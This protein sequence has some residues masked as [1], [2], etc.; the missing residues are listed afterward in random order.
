M[1]YITVV[2]AVFLLPVVSEA[3]ETW[4]N[5]SK[6]PGW[7]KSSCCGSADAHHLRPDQV[8]RLYNE[9]C[10]NGYHG[11]CWKVDGYH[12]IVWDNAV[13]PSQDGAYWG[14]WTDNFV[15]C[16]ALMSCSSDSV[17]QSAMYCFFAPMTF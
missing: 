4:T 6:V 17:H 12:G 5:G 7:V 8:H 2:A 14:F 1:K 15:S 9:E 3:H 11:G 16:S 13:L 10:R